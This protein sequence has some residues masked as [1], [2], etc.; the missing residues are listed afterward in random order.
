MNEGWLEIAQNKYLVAFYAVIVWYAF[1]FVIHKDKQ[2]EKNGSFKIS[3]WWKKIWDNV[4][5]TFLV[6]PFVVLFDAEILWLFNSYHGDED[7]S[8]VSKL[9]YI[10][11]GPLV[12]IIIIAI[13]K[14]TK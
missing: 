13:K 7:F 2:D 9:V 11:A 1:H 4:L 10:S 6:A 12:S 8:S 3:R 5:L 14:F